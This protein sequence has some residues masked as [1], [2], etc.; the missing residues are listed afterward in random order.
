MTSAR[1]IRSAV[2]KFVGCAF[3]LMSGLPLLESA[4]RGHGLAGLR[5]VSL[6]FVFGLP[7]LMSVG[8]ALGL[9]ALSSRLDPTAVG[10]TV[11]HAV[12]AITAI[13][14]LGLLSMMTQGAHRPFV[15][16]ACLSAGLIASLA[17]FLRPRRSETSVTA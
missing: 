3:V 1:E 9:I 5:G 14:M 16:A 2:P 4:I 6:P 13:L 15:F 7:L 8:Y 10:R 17:C 12:A 11:R